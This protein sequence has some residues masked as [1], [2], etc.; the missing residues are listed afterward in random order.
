LTDERQNLTSTTFF[1]SRSE[2]PGVDFTNVFARI[3][4][5]RLSYERLFSSCV[6]QKMSAKNVGEIDP[7]PQ[8]HQRST[9]SVYVNRSQ[10]RKF[11]D[12]RDLT[13]FALL[14]SLSVKALCKHVG[15]NDPWSKSN[16][17][18]MRLLG[19]LTPLN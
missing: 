18:F 19:H 7:L 14:E 11:K 15:K 3:F 6:L 5:V 1:T 9:S 17:S 16:K 4:H 8:F 10:K 13:F 12:T 2:I